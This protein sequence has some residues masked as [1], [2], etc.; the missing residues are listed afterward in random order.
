MPVIWLHQ[1]V[2][3][4]DFQKAF[5]SVN[6][7]ILLLKLEYHGVRKTSKTGFF[8]TL[9]TVPSLAQKNTERSPDTLVTHGVPPGSVLEPLPFLLFINDM[10]KTISNETLRH[11]SDDTNLLIVS[12]SVKDINRKVNYNFRLIQDWLEANKL[13]LN[14]SKADIISFQEKTRKTTNISIFDRLTEKFT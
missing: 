2:E 9:I 12:K 8:L 11:F 7:D 14:P 1:L 5:D 3:F 13:C 6:H 10:H 4:Q